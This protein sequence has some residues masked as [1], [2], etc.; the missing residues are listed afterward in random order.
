MVSY[1]KGYT[2]EVNREK[3][4]AGYNLL[5]YNI[6]RDSDGYMPVDSFEDSN[7]KVRDKLKQLIQRINNEHLED[8]PWCEKEDSI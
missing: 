5:Y 7:E 3:C 1:Y 2:L 8:D 6:T 4:M